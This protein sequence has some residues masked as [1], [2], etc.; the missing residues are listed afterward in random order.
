M[1]VG[2]PWSSTGTTRGGT[3]FPLKSLRGREYKRVPSADDLRQ[4]IKRRFSYF[5]PPR[6]NPA[7]RG[8]RALP[9]AFVLSFTCRRSSPAR[10]SCRRSDRRPPRSGVGPVACARPAA[11]THLAA[12]SRWVSTVPCPCCRLSPSWGR[13]RL[14]PLRRNKK[15]TGCVN[16]GCVWR[17]VARLRSVRG[18]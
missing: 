15:T 6:Q 8:C 11:W 12:C 9:A 10:N 3:P 7:K 13:E 16:E 1:E 4:K 17:R 14:R 2:P 18:F 5:T